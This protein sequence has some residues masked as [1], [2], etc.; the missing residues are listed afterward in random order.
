M[1]GYITP[2]DGR[3]ASLDRESCDNRENELD[4]LHPSPSSENLVLMTVNSACETRA[5]RRHPYGRI[6]ARSEGKGNENKG[7][8]EGKVNVIV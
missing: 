6:R 2:A 7:E 1:S 5:Y 4:E 8:G 3:R